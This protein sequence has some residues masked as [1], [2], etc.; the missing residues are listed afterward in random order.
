M[1]HAG[2]D[3][4]GSQFFIT[5][6]PTPHLNPNIERES[7]HTVFGRVVKGM[8]VALALRVGD[9]I[10]SAKVLRKREHAYKPETLPDPR[11]SSPGKKPAGKK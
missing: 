3:T 9:T 8:D 2:K 10:E 4:G 5:H 6:L 11:R 7:G 1:A